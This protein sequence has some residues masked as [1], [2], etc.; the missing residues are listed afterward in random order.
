MMVLNKPTSMPVHA[1][2]QYKV[3]TVLGLLWK[4]NGI[5]GLRGKIELKDVTNIPQ[6]T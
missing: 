1:C 4:L 2:G 3:N 6:Q 5:R